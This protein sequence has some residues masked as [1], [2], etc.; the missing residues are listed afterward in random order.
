MYPTWLGCLA[1]FLKGV[2]WNL[3]MGFPNLSW[4]TCAGRTG[5]LMPDFFSLSPPGVA[6]EKLR[7]S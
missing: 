3:S 5:T 6:Q 1:A 2:P 4:L 7:A